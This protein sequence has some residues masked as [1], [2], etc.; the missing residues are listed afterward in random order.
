M[1]FDEAVETLSAYVG[2]QYCLTNEEHQDKQK[3]MAAVTVLRNEQDRVLRPFRP[4][5]WYTDARD[6]LCPE[7]K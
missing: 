1:T 5:R 3:A 7:A 6:G 4:L 2:W